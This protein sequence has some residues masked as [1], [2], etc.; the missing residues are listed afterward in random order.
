MGWG[1]GVEEQFSEE[2]TFRAESRGT[3][4]SQPCTPGEAHPGRRSTDAK[5]LIRLRNR[6]DV[7]TG[8]PVRTEQYQEREQRGGLSA[9]LQIAG[10]HLDFNL[11][12][13]AFGVKWEKI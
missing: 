1:W 4:E 11:T 10:G 2:N 8:A 5:A 6:N 3:R 12:V 7:M 9:G 13:E